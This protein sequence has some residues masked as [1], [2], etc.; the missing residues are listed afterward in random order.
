MRK[1]RKPDASFPYADP[2]V[3]IY[4]YVDGEYFYACT[5][6][7]KLKLLTAIND[8]SRVRGAAKL[9]GTWPGQKRSDVFALNLADVFRALAPHGPQPTTHTP[10]APDPFPAQKAPLR[11]ATA[12]AG[13]AVPAVPELPVQKI[14]S[15]LPVQEIKPDDRR[16]PGPPRRGF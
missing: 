7:E 4:G 14:N 9:I 2:R 8:S 11:T 12:P 5:V 1:L 15:P 6:E 10:A 13:D 3:A 16:L